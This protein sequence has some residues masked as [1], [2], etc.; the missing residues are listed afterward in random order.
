V[1]L[2]EVVPPGD[3]DAVAAEVARQLAAFRRLMGRDPT[4]LDSRQHVHRREPALAVLA[5]LAAELDVPVRHFS[6]EV[7]YCGDFYGQD[8]DGSPLPGVVS[9]AELTRILAALPPGRTDLACHPGDAQDLD[10]M[11]RDE[12]REECAVLC[13]ASV[14]EF[15]RTERIEIRSFCDLRRRC[16]EVA[17]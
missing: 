6:A 13:D 9:V 12:R 4:H 15:L 3:R 2:Y 1:P 17:R 14:R 5:A 8:A 7:R 10:T 11:Y 16:G